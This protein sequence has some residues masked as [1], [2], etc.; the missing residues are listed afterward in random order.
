MTDQPHPFQPR[1]EHAFTVSIDLTK[2][3]YLKPSSTGMTR[4]AVWAAQGKVEGKINGIVLPMSGGD[5]PLVR[6]DGV[7]DFDARYLF[8]LD[9]GTHVYL[10]SRGYRWGTEEAMAKMS[11]NEPVADHEYYMR[12]SPKFDVPDGPHAWLNRHIFV[13][14][15]EK[16]PGANRIH[17]FQVL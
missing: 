4:A 15:A 7:I 13:G 9:D 14:V 5:F 2:A 17:Y 12:V 10:Q 3:V 11:R 16:V 6:A 8:E 1:L